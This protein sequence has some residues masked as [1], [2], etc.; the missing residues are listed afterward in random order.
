MINPAARQMTSA[1]KTAKIRPG[2]AVRASSSPPSA[3][4]CCSGA[5]RAIVTAAE[6]AAHRTPCAGEHPSVSVELEPVARRGRERVELEGDVGR[7]RAGGKLARVDRGGRLA[8]ERSQPEIHR[9][10][11][12]VTKRPGARVELDGGS[13]EEAAARERLVLVIGQ[14]AVAEGQ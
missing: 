1:R 13:G 3:A 2:T 12:G 4:G 14:P 6:D 8:L 5:I 11:D 9:L 10:G 7:I